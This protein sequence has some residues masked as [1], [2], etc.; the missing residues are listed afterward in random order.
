MREGIVIIGVEDST[1]KVVGMPDER[2]GETMDVILRA[3]RQVIKPELVL[4]PLE[5]EVYVLA[6]NQIISCKVTRNEEM[7]WKWR[8][9]GRS[10]Q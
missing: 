3:A 10:L 7:L 1:H 9:L 6:G 8:G 5:P 4:D 2:I